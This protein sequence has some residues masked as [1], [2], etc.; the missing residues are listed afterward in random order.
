MSSCNYFKVHRTSTTFGRKEGGILC[1]IARQ[2]RNQQLGFFSKSGSIFSAIKSKLDGSLLPVLLLRCERGVLQHTAHVHT[3]FKA[4]NSSQKF[5]LALCFPSAV[6]FPLRTTDAN[7]SPSR[8]NDTSRTLRSAE[9]RCHLQERS[10]RDAF[11]LLSHCT[12]KPSSL[13]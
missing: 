6:C 9:K 8:G 3:K 2:N 7:G 4:A 11:P 10:F 12:E 5:F 1:S 13:A